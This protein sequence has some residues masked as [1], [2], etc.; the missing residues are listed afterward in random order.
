MTQDTLTHSTGRP[1][2]NEFRFTPRVLRRIRHLARIGIGGRAIARRLGCEYGSLRNFCSGQGVSLKVDPVVIEKAKAAPI[3][4]LRRSGTLDLLEVPV[5]RKIVD[6][7]R[8][9]ALR[10]G[11]AAEVLMSRI[12]EL[13]AVDNMIAAIIDE[14]AGA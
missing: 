2:S 3:A 12:L 11:V 13:A 10:Y 1:G 7:Y 4:V 5:G 9:E 14:E 8:R 6:T